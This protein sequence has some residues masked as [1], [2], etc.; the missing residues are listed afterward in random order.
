VSDGP[1]V[2]LDYDQAA[3][4]R[5]YDQTAWAPNMQEVLQRRGQWFDGK[6]GLE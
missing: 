2:F 4:D 5:A 1:K 6:P 3:L